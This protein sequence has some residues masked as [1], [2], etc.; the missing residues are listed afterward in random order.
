MSIICYTVDLMNE[1]LDTSELLAFTRT[2]DAK[3]FSRAAA[4]LGVPRPTIGRRLARLERRLRV[5]LLR[6]TTRTIALTDAGEAFLRHARIALDALEAAEAS[7]KN[8]DNV[9]RGT[10]RVAIPPMQDT[11]FNSLVCDFARAY[12]QVQVQVDASARYVDLVRDGYDVAL[13]TG[14][15]LE[16]GLVGR[17][18][19]RTSAIAVASPEYLE[20]YG[21]PRTARDLRGHRCLVGFMRGELPQTH[22]PK[23]GGGKMSV[24]GAIVSNEV[25]LLLEAALRGH[26][27]ALLPTWLLGAALR[28]GELVRVL[29]SVVQGESRL[30]VVYQEKELLPP[31]VRAFIDV[32][33]AWAP[34]AVDAARAVDRRRTRAPRAQER[35]TARRAPRRT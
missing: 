31:Q 24:E 29:P 7:V 14:A 19:A 25:T 26:G 32:L 15:D 16:P 4:E 13:R 6:R 22:W 18:I 33:V 8:S 10:L 20:K 2:V 28:R 35:S 12:P 3:S 30:T 1:P 9:V 21:T 5:R 17:T 23:V 27:V 34:A 11:S